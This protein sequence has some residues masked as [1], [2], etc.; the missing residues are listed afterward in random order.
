MGWRLDARGHKSG[1]GQN[2]MACSH[3]DLNSASGRYLTREKEKQKNRKERL[4]I[5]DPLFMTRVFEKES[6]Y[7]LSKNIT[8]NKNVCREI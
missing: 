7:L 5:T 1:A 6:L 2:G 8:Q 3:Q 4:E